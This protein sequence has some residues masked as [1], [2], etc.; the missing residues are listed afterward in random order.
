MY[1]I[2]SLELGHL[3][4]IR[5]VA[6]TGKPLILSTGT[7]SWQEI[8][9]AV[10]AA[11]TAGC[12]QLLL[13]H[14]VS[15]Y[16]TPPDQANLATMAAVRERFGHPVGLSDHTVGAHVAVAAAALGAVCVE[17]HVTLARADGG[18]DAAFSMEPA[19]LAALRVG[20]DTAWSARGQV[21]EACLP[22][23]TPARELRRSLYVVADV[24]QG[25]QL[26]EH[27][28]RAIR[29]GHGLPPAQLHEVLGRRAARP[30]RRG[31]PLDRS[32]LAPLPTPTTT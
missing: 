18:V 22:S 3:P 32:M 27:H 4:L 2:A 8:A 14:C 17:K 19:E 30:L 16:P 29:P 25:S 6:A 20:L 26:T 24:P 31:E 13:L 12:R 10:E 11:R 7:A 28:I 15:G 1:K 21:R 5:A 23:E 9:E